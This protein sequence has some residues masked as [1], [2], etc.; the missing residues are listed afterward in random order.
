MEH[1]CSW[2]GSCFSTA[3]FV[4]WRDERGSAWLPRYNYY[5]NSCPKVPEM[6]SIPD[7]TMARLILHFPNCLPSSNLPRLATRCSISHIVQGTLS[8]RLPTFRDLQAAGSHLGDKG[9][10]K[11]PMHGLL[12]QPSILSAEPRLDY[13]PNRLLIWMAGF[14]IRFVKG[15][16]SAG[17]CL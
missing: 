4:W 12:G 9:G 15:F 17:V 10:M 13:Y 1:R 6:Q 5:G 14:H 3:P 8:K 11:L 7:Y 2:R 16:T